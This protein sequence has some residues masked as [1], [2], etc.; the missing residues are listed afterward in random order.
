MYHGLTPAGV[1]THVAQRHRSLIKRRL[2]V[3]ALIVGICTVLPA[4][5]NAR[6]WSVVLTPN[7]SGATSSSLVS[8]SCSWPS[9]CMAVGSSTDSSGHA[10]AL[11]EQWDGMRWVIK[12]VPTPSGST[13]STFTSVSCQLTTACTA[14]GS[15]TDSTGAHALV[16]RWN[17]VAWSIW[18]AP[19]TAGLSGVSCTSGRACTAIGGDQIVRWNGQTW[20]TQ[21]A[22][23]P[24]GTLVFPSTVSC[25]AADACAAV[26]SLDY[27]GAPPAATQGLAGF[28]DGT[29]WSFQP[30]AAGLPSSL[31]DVSCATASACGAVGIYNYSFSAPE[32]WAA[33]WDGRTWLAQTTPN[34]GFSAVLNGV[35]CWSAR[36]CTAVGSYFATGPT[37]TL[38]EQ[39]NGTTW[40]VQPT[41]DPVSGSGSLSGVS[42]DWPGVCMAV[43]G[44]SAGRTLAERYK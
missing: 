8:V 16:E 2:K 39:R 3:I 41:P 38:A 6:T 17:T 23:P 40:S 10:A 42:C 7:P 36:A 24:S 20:T 5:A 35:S 21:S 44:D 30:I 34:P 29:A 12:P 32:P 26:G 4:A 18:P 1:E 27:L 15:N 14:V 25:P 13:D 11:A 28:W 43:G 22:Q 31:E 9:A 19:T 37:L 33:A